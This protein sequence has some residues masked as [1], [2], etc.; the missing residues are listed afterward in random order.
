MIWRSITIVH[1]T[2]NEHYF[3]FR[4]VSP[5]ARLVAA[6]FAR[7]FSAPTML[8]S[9]VVF[10]AV[11]DPP[12][13]PPPPL[14]PVVAA[15]APAPAANVPVP[16]SSLPTSSSSSSSSSSRP[17]KATFA[18]SE[19]TPFG[20][21]RK[22]ARQ[23]R[24]LARSTHTT[25]PLADSEL[26]VDRQLCQSHRAINLHSN[27]RVCPQTTHVGAIVPVLQLHLK[28]VEIQYL[29]RLVY[30]LVGRTK[31]FRDADSFGLTQGPA[32]AWKEPGREADAPF[33]AKG[34]AYK[35][36]CGGAQ[37]FLANLVV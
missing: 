11:V 14:S 13:P 15:A 28:A 30:V 37:A 16:T 27:S 29:H 23:I 7:L 3:V 17:A 18:A 22:W 25:C 34:E 24:L 8:V 26:C 12:P 6:L 1:N 32:Y 19:G 33:A 9:G 4:G 20:K 31:L 5:A 35:R 36:P 10:V 21:T 2:V